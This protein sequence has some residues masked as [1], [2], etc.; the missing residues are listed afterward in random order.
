MQSAPCHDPLSAAASRSCLFPVEDP[1]TSFRTGAREMA[2]DGEN[3]REALHGRTTITCN[4][5]V[6]CGWVEFKSGAELVDGT[7]W[8]F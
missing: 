1:Q 2:R 6:A 7:L 4:S 8:R 3:S 5:G